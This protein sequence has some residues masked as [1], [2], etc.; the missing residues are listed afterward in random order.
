MKVYISN[1]GIVDSVSQNIAD[2][3]ERLNAAKNIRPYAPTS[4]KYYDYVCNIDDVINKISKEIKYINNSLIKSEKK[5][6][7]LFE[8][9]IIKINGLEE[10]VL[11]D[12][13]GLIDIF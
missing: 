13:N 12:R 3:K 1:T 4:F 11:P 10:T 5:Y 8:N 6:N 2:A 9:E 7:R